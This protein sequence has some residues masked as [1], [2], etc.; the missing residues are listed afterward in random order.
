MPA[1]MGTCGRSRHP[2]PTRGRFLHAGDQHVGG[3]AGLRRG[4]R[5]RL[6]LAAVPRPRKAMASASSSLPS[7]PAGSFL[8]WRWLSVKEPDCPRRRAR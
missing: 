3:V 6:V 4:P 7:F 5:D 2:S 1:W 8:T